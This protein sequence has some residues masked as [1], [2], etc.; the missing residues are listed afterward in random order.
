M[1]NDK[2][3]SNVVR[4]KKEETDTSG[5]W[6]RDE[7]MPIIYRLSQAT[8]K[9]K[10]VDYNYVIKKLSPGYRVSFFVGYG[11]KVLMSSLPAQVTRILNRWYHQNSSVFEALHD[12]GEKLIITGNFVSVNE[13]SKFLVH[14]VIKDE[15]VYLD[16]DSMIRLVYTEGTNGLGIEF[17]E[18]DKHFTLTVD[19]K[20]GGV[21][22]RTH[23]E[24]GE[25]LIVGYPVTSQY[26]VDLK[27]EEKH[28]VTGD[29]Y[30]QSWRSFLCSDT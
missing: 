9:G 15:T 27:G 23:P 13:I 2:M 22:V 8:P 17:E 30:H 14:F 20:D 25:G 16:T 12:R 29:T 7:L 26:I 19:K 18:V 10:V 11:E 1:L 28:V 21:M 6:P 24:L 3:V 5:Y 4:F